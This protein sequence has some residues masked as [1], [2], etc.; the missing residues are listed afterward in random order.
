MSNDT[1]ESKWDFGQPS[2]VAGEKR[3]RDP[4]KC[5]PIRCG[6]RLSWQR[7]LLHSTGPIAL[8][9]LQLPT[10]P[11][12]PFGIILL[13]R[14]SPSICCIFGIAISFAISVYCTLLDTIC[15][16]F[17]QYLGKMSRWCLRW[18][19]FKRTSIVPL[20]F[21]L[22]LRMFSRSLKGTQKKLHWMSL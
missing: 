18:S 19:P 7:L 8:C 5:D 2:S 6:E 12:S 13:W 15:F 10:S 16:L 1:T 20:S 4:R 11:T 22:C 17:H 14:D 21:W 3:V 9:Y